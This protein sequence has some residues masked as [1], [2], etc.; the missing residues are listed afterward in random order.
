MLVEGAAG[1]GKTALMD[2][3]AAAADAAG[4]LVLRARGAELERAFGFGVVRQLFEPVVHRELFTGAARLAAPV[5]GIDHTAAPAEDPFAARHALYWLTANLAA[6]RPLA[7]LV[8]DAHWADAASLGALAHLANRLQGIAVALVVASRTEVSRPRW[9]R[10]A[11]TRHGALTCRRSV[12]RPRP[13]WSARSPRQPTT[14]SAAPAATPPAAT[15][16]CCSE[17]A[18]RRSPPASGITADTSPERVTREIGQRLATAGGPRAQLA[19]AA[20]VLGDGVALRRAAQ[21]AGLDDAAAAMAADALV[22]A[23]SCAG[24]I[25]SSSCTR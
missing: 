17:L 12:R 13:P 3:A 22:A 10:C 9:R 6:E 25:R 11:I 15:R 21:L 14:R 19:R 8:D 4:L 5:L 7:L 2:A 18:R 24:R 20:A 23:A 16:S 1:A